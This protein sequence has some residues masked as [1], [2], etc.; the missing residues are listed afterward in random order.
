[1]DICNTGRAEI[2][3]RILGISRLLQCYQLVL[4]LAANQTVSRVVEGRR[5]T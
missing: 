3:F 4:G 1:M 2:A 5:H